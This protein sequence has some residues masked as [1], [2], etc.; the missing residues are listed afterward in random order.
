MKKFI[1][2]IIFI[3]SAV[4]LAIVCS[5]VMQKFVKTYETD[6]SLNIESQKA[7]GTSVFCILPQKEGLLIGGKQFGEI[8][9]AIE[10]ME[11]NKT[12]TTIDKTN[13]YFF[14]TDEEADK[15]FNPGDYVTP[16]PTPEINNSSSQS[17]TTQKPNN[18]KPTISNQTSQS[19]SKVEVTE[20]AI[21]VAEELAKISETDLYF[22]QDIVNLTD[23]V[24]SDYNDVLG[25]ALIGDFATGT[26]TINNLK[27]D[28]EKIKA[29]K[30]EDSELQKVKDNVIKGTECFINGFTQYFNYDMEANTTLKAADEYFYKAQE[31]LDGFL[32]TLKE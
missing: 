4:I 17:Q 21:V 27:K 6:T 24:I 2:P 22:L 29:L 15:F 14:D 12:N 20:E 26:A 16:I 31:Q 32:E 9:E 13:D 10:I 30:V 7:R 3:A 1:Q 18:T 25:Y 28:L 8:T 11:H 19:S 5:F 23:M